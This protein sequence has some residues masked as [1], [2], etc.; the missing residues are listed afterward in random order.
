[1]AVDPQ[2][3]KSGRERIFRGGS[4]FGNDGGD[5][6]G[7]NSVARLP[8]DPKKISIYVGFG[9]VVLPIPAKGQASSAVPVRNR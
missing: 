6:T 5:L 9:R 3:P 7:I 1:V 8:F 2:G 4:K